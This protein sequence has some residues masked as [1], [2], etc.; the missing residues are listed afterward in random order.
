[1]AKFKA[2]DYVPEAKARG[3]A[4]VRVKWVEDQRGPDVVRSRSVCFAGTPPLLLVR[5]ILRRVASLGRDRCWRTLGGRAS[6][7]RRAGRR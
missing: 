2:W 3:G 6:G 7:A 1:M 5:Y 4:T